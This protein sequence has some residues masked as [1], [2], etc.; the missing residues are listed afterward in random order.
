MFVWVGKV[1]DGVIAIGRIVSAE[2][3]L[4][5]YRPSLSLI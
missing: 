5:V 3:R 4:T 1:A 2:F